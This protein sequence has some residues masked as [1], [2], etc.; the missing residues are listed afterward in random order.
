MNEKVKFIYSNNS[1]SQKIMGDM[2]DLDK[3]EYIFG[4]R[5]TAEFDINMYAERMKRRDRVRG[6]WTQDNGEASS[7]NTKPNEDWNFRFTQMLWTMWDKLLSD[8]N[9]M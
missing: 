9:T 6:S 2:F 7:N 1:E 4:G 3:L 8:K 5:N